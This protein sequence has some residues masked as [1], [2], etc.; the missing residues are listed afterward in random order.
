LKASDH[1]GSTWLTAFNEVGEA[2]LGCG[3]SDLN[4]L[5]EAEVFIAL[6][7]IYFFYLCCFGVLIKY[8]FFS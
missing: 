7:I 4:N 6:S 2:L 8:I 5:R 1:T 3:A